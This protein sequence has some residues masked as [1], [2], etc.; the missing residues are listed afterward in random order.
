MYFATDTVEK[1]CYIKPS[2]GALIGTM[3]NALC[4]NIKT[5]TK[6]VF[7]CLFDKSTLMLNKKLVVE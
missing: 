7:K 6:L 4:S 5:K 2:N 3:E 1:K